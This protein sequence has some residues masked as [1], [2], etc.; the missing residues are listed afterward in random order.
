MK[1]YPLY[2]NLSGLLFYC[3]ICKYMFMSVSV[4]LYS[5]FPSLLESYSET[6]MHGNL[7]DQIKLRS[8]I[9]CSFTGVTIYC[10]STPQM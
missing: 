9:K 4:R 1:V 7:F 8:R 6:R 10:I 2:V 5:L 3:I